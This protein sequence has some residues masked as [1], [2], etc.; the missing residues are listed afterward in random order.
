ME[1]EANHYMAIGMF[2]SFIVLIFM[3]YPVA[4]LMGGL[5]IIFT[6]ISATSDTYLDTFLGVDWGYSRIVVTR[7]YAVMN[8]WVLVA[9]PMF[10][11]MGI[12]LDRS[13]IAED[14]M[15]DLSKLFG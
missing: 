7:I 8:N 2:L 6:A 4:W 3:G 10:I 5:A 9:L 12:M 14:L 11:F 1:L 15:N 13:A